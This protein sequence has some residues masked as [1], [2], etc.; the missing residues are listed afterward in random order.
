MTAIH[1]TPIR[2]DGKTFRSWNVSCDRQWNGSQF[3]SWSV[4]F[5]TGS[6]KII[7]RQIGI[8]THEA[9]QDIANDFIKQFAIR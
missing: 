2:Y 8:Q 5:F 1:N 7:F 9:A 6:G 4:T 3:T